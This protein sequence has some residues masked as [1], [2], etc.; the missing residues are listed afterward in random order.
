MITLVNRDLMIYDLEYRVADILYE[1]ATYGKVELNT[2]NEGIC[3]NNVKFYE[4][5]DYICEKFNIDK[6]SVTIYTKNALEHHDNYNIVIKSNHWLI[7]SKKYAQLYYQPISKQSQ[8]KTLGCFVGQVNWKRLIVSSW[9]FNN[10]KDKCLMSFNYRNSDADKLLSDLT[11]V[12]FYNSSCIEEAV[13]FLKQTPIYV[14]NLYHFKNTNITYEEHWKNV[15]NLLKFYDQF[16]LDL[17]VETYSMGNTF[18]PTEKSIRPFIAKTPFITVGPVNFLTNLKKL[19]FKTF[20]RWW[21]E[22]YDWCEGV[23]RINEIKKVIAKIMLW[24]N[25]KLLST[26]DEMS[27]VL[28]HNFGVYMNT[29]DLQERL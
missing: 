4:I 27:E 19:G 2:N 9:L 22:S 20:N 28:E 21:D 24:P 6:K 23:H 11:I 16:F 8:L 15:L 12:N 17:V 10:Y 18:F 5:L 25:D 29:K 14:D 3:L 7:D 26:L 13:G 1:Y